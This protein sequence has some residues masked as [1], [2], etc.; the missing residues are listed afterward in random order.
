MQSYLCLALLYLLNNELNML[1]CILDLF[2]LKI[3][4][5]HNKLL[6]K[7]VQLVNI[8]TFSMLHII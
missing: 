1:Y 6:S 3:I 2:C 8:I 7:P 4:S 5:K